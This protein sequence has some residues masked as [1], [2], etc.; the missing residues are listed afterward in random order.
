M[1]GDIKWRPDVSKMAFVWDAS[2]I[3]AID[4]PAN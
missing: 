2:N 4:V 1:I 3:Y